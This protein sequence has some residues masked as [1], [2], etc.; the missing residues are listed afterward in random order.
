MIMY[1]QKNI[2]KI[3]NFVNKLFLAGKGG[4]TENLTTESTKKNR[5]WEGKKK[6]FGNEGS[7]EKLELTFRRAGYQDVIRR[8]HWLH[9]VPQ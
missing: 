2:H 4:K 7:S 9:T 1:M 3:F 5:K 8:N 6:S